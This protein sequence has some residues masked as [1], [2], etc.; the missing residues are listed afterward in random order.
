MRNS[1]YNITGLHAAVKLCLYVFKTFWTTPV[2]IKRVASI[3]PVHIAILAL[4]LIQAYHRF[5]AF[6]PPI[7][8][9]RS[10]SAVFPT[11]G[12]ALKQ[13]FDLN[14]FENVVKY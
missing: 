7:S 9:I 1:A 10:F 6:H 14:D 4:N 5:H 2:I 12:L 13:L 8:S 11:S 3:Y